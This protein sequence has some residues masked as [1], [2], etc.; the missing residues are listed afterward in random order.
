MEAE[1]TQS[2][3]LLK[4]TFLEPS[5]SL[6]MYLAMKKSNTNHKMAEDKFGKFHFDEEK[7]KQFGQACK[8][9]TKRLEEGVKLEQELTGESEMDDSLLIDPESFSTPPTLHF[10]TQPSLPMFKSPSS[11]D[12]V[13][14]NPRREK[15]GKTIPLTFPFPE[16]SKRRNKYLDFAHSMMRELENQ[17]IVSIDRSV[18]SEESV[19][20]YVRR[21]SKMGSTPSSETSDVD[22]KGSM[23]TTSKFEAAKATTAQKSEY[24]AIQGKIRLV[25]N[26]IPEKLKMMGVMGGAI[27]FQWK[28]EIKTPEED[29]IT[30]AK[31]IGLE[32]FISLPHDEKIFQVLKHCYPS[33]KIINNLH[34]HYFI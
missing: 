26:D 25:L 1:K 23:A 14:M 29:F 24:Y 28:K 18:E 6:T 31:S 34:Y 22:D 33:A 2:A 7:L 32:K 21:I 20:Y 17:H 5:N 9:Q 15:Q 27:W 12:L 30:T 8:E 10:P 11:V 13:T 19:T 3:N 4:I 16:K